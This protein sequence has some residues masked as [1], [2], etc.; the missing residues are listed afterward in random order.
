MRKLSQ[1]EAQVSVMVVENEKLRREA[2]IA[3]DM[4]AQELEHLRAETAAAQRIIDEEKNAHTSTRVQVTSSAD[5]FLG[6]GFLA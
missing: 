2:A 6:T 5:P 3:A 1:V 4:S